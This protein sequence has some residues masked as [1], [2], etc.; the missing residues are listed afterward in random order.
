MA[1]HVYVWS[2]R[3][4][5][6]G[7]SSRRDAEGGANDDT[8]NTVSVEKVANIADFEALLQRLVAAGQ[9]VDLLEFH[10]HG[11]GGGV[12]MGP[13]SLTAV[14]LRDWASKGYD[15]AFSPGA[16]ID[17]TGCNCAETAFGDLLLVH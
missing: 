16:E 2:D 12:G 14:Q 6:I 7:L 1:Y 13:E 3:P 8:G 9:K 10:T 11:G 15:R 5:Q 17:L 4:G